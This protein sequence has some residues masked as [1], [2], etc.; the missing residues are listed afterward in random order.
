MLYL[1]VGTVVA[2]KSIDLNLKRSLET[3]GKAGE[4]A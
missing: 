4:V 2:A 3:E 1:R